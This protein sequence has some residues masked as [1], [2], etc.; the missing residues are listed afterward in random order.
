MAADK[1]QLAAMYNL[2]VTDPNFRTILANSA[3]PTALQ[4]AIVQ[5]GWAGKFPG[6]VVPMLSSQQL[7]VA[8]ASPDADEIN[9]VASGAPIAEGST[10][11]WAMDYITD[12]AVR[13]CIIQPGTTNPAQSK[14]ADLL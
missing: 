1:W 12:R 14:Q 6:A 2:A 11:A 3:T 13:N 5:N 10:D 4:S 8:Q 7:A 9:L